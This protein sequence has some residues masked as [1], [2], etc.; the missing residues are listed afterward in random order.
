MR[1]QGMVPAAMLATELGSDGFES[2]RRRP[3]APRAPLG[4]Q[5]GRRGPPSG[6]LATVKAVLLASM[7]DGFVYGETGSGGTFHPGVVV[8]R[9]AGNQ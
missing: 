6:L 3:Q 1:W 2:P 7:I 9:R 4:A 8:G 5:P